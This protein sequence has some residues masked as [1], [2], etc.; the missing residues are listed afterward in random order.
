MAQG[1][2]SEKIIRLRCGVC[3]RVNYTTRKNKK[4]IERKIEFKRFCR[5]CRKHTLHKEAK[6]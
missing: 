6:K 4:L 3:K 5:W 1:K 2:F